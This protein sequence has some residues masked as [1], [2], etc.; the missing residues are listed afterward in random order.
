MTILPSLHIKAE[1]L[2]E[3]VAFFARINHYYAIIFETRGNVG[4][5]Q[6]TWVKH[7]H[8]VRFG[9]FGSYLYRVLKADADKGQDRCTS[10]FRAKAGEGVGILTFAYGC[11]CQ[12]FRRGNGSLTAAT[13]P[14]NLNKTVGIY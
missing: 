5:R 4:N 2:P 9:N 3:L 7:D 10:S 12:Q 11:Q 1:F 14:P 6:Q 13:M 8:Y